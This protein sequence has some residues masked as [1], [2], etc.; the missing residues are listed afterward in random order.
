M[1]R[2]SKAVLTGAALLALASAVTAQTATPMGDA[3]VTARLAYL[4]GALEGGRHAADLWSR[5]WL[6]GY[7]VAAGGQLAARSSSGDEE[8]RQDLTVGA[9]TSALGVAGLAVFPVEA[10]RFARRLRA[11]P[12]DTPEA[13]RAKLAVAE[14]FLREAAA[15][16]ATG[17]SWKAHAASAAV[18]LAAGLVI[19]KHYDRP[20]RD[21]LLT[22]AVGQLVSEVQIFTQPTRARRDLRNYESR[23]DFSPPVA[24]GRLRPDWY[25]GAAPGGLVVGVRF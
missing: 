1:K 23:S 7:A 5:G 24:T 18:N 19:W 11:E 21:G 12:A 10:G 14:R 17:R 2:F 15:Q 8:Q 20:A 25:V 4:E 16:E 9:A 3:E 6:A 22:F 13:R